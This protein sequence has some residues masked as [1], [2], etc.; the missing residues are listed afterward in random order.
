M[1]DWSN[2]LVLPSPVDK[3]FHSSLQDFTGALYIKR[4]DIIHPDFGGNKWRKLVYNLRE[5]E[6][7]SYSHI[8]TMGGPF[9]NHIAATAEACATFGY[10]SV[11]IIRGMMKDL[12]NPTLSKAIKA[13][14][15]IRHVPKDAYRNG[16]KS[17]A[18]SQILKE[19]P[20]PYFIPEGG[21]N[22]LALKGVRELMYELHQYEELY[23]Y[24]I[25]AAGTG[26][27]A[28]GIISASNEEVIV[29]NVL[30]NQGLHDSIRSKLD[31]SLNHWRINHDYHFGGFAK[32]TEELISFINNFKIETGIPLDPIYTGKAMYATL[33]LIFKKQFDGKRI[34]FIHT[35][36]LQGVAAY[37]YLR[38]DKTRLI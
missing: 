1:K 35:G 19:Y 37:N 6:R 5:F 29:I 11:G 12:N 3:V 32:T 17:L 31:P 10:P 18:I 22:K 24:I 21:S 23:D 30:K 8:I 2:S 38:K 16:K 15:E 28:A 14:M 9:S 4:E 27:T 20:V 34:L 7:G 13:G 36:G 33:D 26:T 25:V